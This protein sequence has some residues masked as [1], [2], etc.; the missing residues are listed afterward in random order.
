VRKPRLLLSL[1]WFLLLTARKKR[2]S[3]FVACAG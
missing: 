1:P 2:V 3:R